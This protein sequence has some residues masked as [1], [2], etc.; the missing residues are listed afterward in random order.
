MIKSLPVKK[1][2]MGIQGWGNHA[3]RSTELGKVLAGWR[4]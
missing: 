4:F 2:E 1:R 3:N